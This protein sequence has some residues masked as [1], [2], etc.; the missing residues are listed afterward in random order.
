MASDLRVDVRLTFDSDA[1]AADVSIANGDLAADNGLET[2]MLLSL[3]CDARASRE[4]L[5][6]FGGDDARGWWADGFSNIEGD[7]YGSK[8]W[9][10]EREK[11]TPETLR[12]AKEY[13]QQALRWLVEDEVAQSV[14]VEASWKARGVIALM[15]DVQ[16][17]SVPR[18]RFAFVWAQ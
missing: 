9:L 10:L 5:E 14:T 6:Q 17:P 18:E 8:L 13:A 16:R 7:G 11:E 12:R 4:E 3:F 1:L 15:I 2:A